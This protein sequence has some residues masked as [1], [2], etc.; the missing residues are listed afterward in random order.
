MLRIIPRYRDKLYRAHHDRTLIAPIRRNRVKPLEGEAQVIARMAVKHRDSSFTRRRYSCRSVARNVN[1]QRRHRINSTYTVG[2]CDRHE[3]G[4]RTCR[5][6]GDIFLRLVAL[7]TMRA[8]SDHLPA[9]SLSAKFEA[10]GLP[11]AKAS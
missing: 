2:V 1:E 9:K 10:T 4:A 5:R 7:N 8:S 6:G 3:V 11:P